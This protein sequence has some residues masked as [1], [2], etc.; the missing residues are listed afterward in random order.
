MCSLARLIRSKC[1]INYFLLREGIISSSV[2]DYTNFVWANWIVFETITLHTGDIHSDAALIFTDIL[3]EV[4]EIM[5]I[6]KNFFFSEIKNTTNHAQSFKTDGTEK[7]ELGGGSDIYRQ[8]FWAKS[9]RYM[10]RI[11]SDTKTKSYKWFFFRLWVR[12]HINWEGHNRLSAARINF[13]FI[14]L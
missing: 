4:W 3:L 10:I 9:N 5:V 6:Q 12:Q 7:H 11:D 1:R 14:I 8:L 13:V 2:T